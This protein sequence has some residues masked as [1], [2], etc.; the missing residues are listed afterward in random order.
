LNTIST[1]IKTIVL[2]A[3]LALINRLN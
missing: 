3:L 1:E 2:L